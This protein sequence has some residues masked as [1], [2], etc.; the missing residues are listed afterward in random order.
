[1]PDH[2]MTQVVAYAWYLYFCLCG[3][4]PMLGRAVV[5]SGIV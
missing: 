2:T 5:A 4:L 3:A 1:M